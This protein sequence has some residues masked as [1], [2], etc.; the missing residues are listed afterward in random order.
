[1]IEVLESL[2]SK[3]SVV[4]ENSIKDSLAD[5]GIGE[6]KLRKATEYSLMGGGKRVRP[7]IIF[8]VANAVGK[9]F[10]VSD[11]AVAIEFVHTSTLIA[12][13][14]PCMDND[15]ER[16]KKPT[17]HVAFN[18]ATALL[19]SYALIAAS[20]NRIRLNA[21]KLRRATNT[22]IAW[23][24]YNLV[25]ENVA[26]NTGVYGVLGGQFDDLFAENYSAE[27]LKSIFS[28][29][30]GALFEISF[31]MG[32]LFGGGHVKYLTD[33]K[34]LANHFGLIFQI[35]DDL[36]DYRQ[37]QDKSETDLNYISILGEDAAR[38]TLNEEAQSAQ[39]ILSSLSIDSRELKVILDYLMMRS[40]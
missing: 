27:N 3:Y 33:I 2:L 15:I 34:K 18:E 8:V 10:D 40:I 16:R 13:D 26:F 5:F 12:D 35:V 9:N 7:L 11:V 24:A 30:T 31:V 20:Y 29:K 14:L 6:N 21:E 37:D 4:I 36:I 19:S 28:R 22:E 25:L 39:D 1:M 17:L 32:W 38:N 23:E